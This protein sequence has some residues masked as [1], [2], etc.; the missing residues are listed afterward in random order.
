[1]DGELNVTTGPRILLIK[2]GGA[3]K[4]GPICPL[5]LGTLDSLDYWTDP[6][7]MSSVRP[8]TA[9]EI[10]DV[11]EQSRLNQQRGRQQSLKG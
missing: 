5:R 11:A 1:M 3:M 10:Y 4:A 8:I 2:G 7:L 6:V 9:Q